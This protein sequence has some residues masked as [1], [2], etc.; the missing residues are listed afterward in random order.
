VFYEK[1]NG[2][3]EEEGFDRFVEGL[4]HAAYADG[5]GR[6]SIPPGVYV[7][8]LF[9]GYFEALESQRGIAWR[10]ADSLSL[11][12]FLGLGLTERTPE[13]S[14][15]TRIRQRLEETIYDE[16]FRFVLAAAVKR[17]LLRG[18][19]IAGGCNDAGSQCGD[20]G[21][22]AAGHGRGLESVPASAGRG[23]GHHGPDGRRAAAV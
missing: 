14:S 6:P 4:C 21:A 17:G 13:H 3:L 7:R 10:C 19:T 18:K 2:V 23:R 5:E 22:G 20:E 12:S 8:M 9:I 1:L 16:V 15:L 11:R